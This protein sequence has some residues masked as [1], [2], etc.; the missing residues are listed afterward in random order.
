ML[1]LA[2]S[3]YLD[4]LLTDIYEPQEPPFLLAPMIGIVLVPM[5]L[6]LSIIGA[7][8]GIFW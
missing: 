5:L 7:I 1:V 6:V 4:R 8:V 3:I 2:A